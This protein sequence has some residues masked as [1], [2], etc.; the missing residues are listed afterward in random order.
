MVFLLLFGQ[1]LAGQVR[2]FCCQ[3]VWYCFGL[4]GSEAV[5]CLTHASIFQP[6]CLRPFVAALWCLGVCGIF[7]VIVLSFFRESFS[8]S[9]IFST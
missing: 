2:W 1:F 8:A 7:Y 4:F 5:V 6:H 3:P 9:C